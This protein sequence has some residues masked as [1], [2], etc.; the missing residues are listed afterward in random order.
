MAE[1]NLRSPDSEP[2]IQMPEQNQPNFD[3]GGAGR[4]KFTKKNDNSRASGR[5]RAAPRI[6]LRYLA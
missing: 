1:R 4:T 5:P 2:E 3:K 6:A